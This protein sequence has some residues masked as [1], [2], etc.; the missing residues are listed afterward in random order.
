MMVPR[1]SGLIVNLSTIGGMVSLFNV[2]YG[3]GKAG[4]DKMAADCAKELKK[5]NITMVRDLK[6]YLHWKFNGS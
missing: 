3:V 5:H 1:K 6:T 2:A 4:Q